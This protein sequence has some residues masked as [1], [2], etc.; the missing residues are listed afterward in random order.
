VPDVRQADQ[1]KL[2]PGTPAHPCHGLGRTSLTLVE[3]PPSPALRK[4]IKQR[5]RHACTAVEVPAPTTTRW[6]YTTASESLMAETTVM[7]T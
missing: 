3:E 2:V 7:R 1:G 6:R 4:R 5:D